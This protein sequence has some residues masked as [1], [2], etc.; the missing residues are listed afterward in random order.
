[1]WEGPI[2]DGSAR[3]QSTKRSKVVVVMWYPI[4]RDKE[5]DT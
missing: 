2:D 3:A 1:M 5:I 4:V